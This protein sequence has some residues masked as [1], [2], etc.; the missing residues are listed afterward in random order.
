MPPAA[1]IVFALHPSAAPGVP[2]PLVMASVT[3]LLSP[4]MVLPAM[5]LMVTCGCVANAVPPVEEAL[6]C[7]VKT[8]CV[9]G[10]LTATVG[11]V[12]M[13]ASG[14]PAEACFV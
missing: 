10:P 13:F 7:C 9:P 3:R 11:C 5:S 4:V 8:S 14:V 2:V 6:G 12:T 1:A